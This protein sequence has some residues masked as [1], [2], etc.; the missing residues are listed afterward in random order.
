MG[1]FNLVFGK[2]TCPRCGDTVDAEVETRLGY[3]HQAVLRVGERYPWNHPAMPPCRPE[4]GNAV[5]DGYCVCP[6][7][8]KDFFV[9]VLIDT[10]V[11]R[12]LEHD[13]TRPGMIPDV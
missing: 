2:M 3:A 8:G 13:A 10:D 4:G 6:A 12:T 11:I 9:N 7:C 5:G 1:L